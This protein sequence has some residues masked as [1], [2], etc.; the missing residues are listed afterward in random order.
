ML[1]N[2]RRS[3]IEDNQNLIL[4]KTRKDKNKW[5]TMKRTWKNWT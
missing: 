4:V 1:I 2:N 5:M 3:I